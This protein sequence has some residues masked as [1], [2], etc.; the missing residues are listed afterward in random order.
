MVTNAAI[1]VVL[2]MKPETNSDLDKA[3]RDYCETLGFTANERGSFVE[4]KYGR[5]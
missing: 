1:S 5:L 4:R 2:G 3:Y